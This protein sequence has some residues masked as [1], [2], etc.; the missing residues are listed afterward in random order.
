MRELWLDPNYQAQELEMGDQI[1]NVHFGIK[2]R[3]VQ[4]PP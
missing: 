1:V 3:N 2:A 4:W